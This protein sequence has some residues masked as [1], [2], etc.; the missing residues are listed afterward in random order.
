MSKDNNNKSRELNNMILDL[1]S[2][3]NEY[4]IKEPEYRTMLIHLTSLAKLFNVMCI[5][6]VTN[7]LMIDQ[8]H[9]S[10]K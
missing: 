4:Y 9:A 6:E 3:V 8:S 1:I 2:Q 5:R 10:D 7:E